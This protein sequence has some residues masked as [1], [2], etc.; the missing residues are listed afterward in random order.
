M[1]IYA[2]IILIALVVNYL[3]DLVSDMLNLQA[4]RQ[5]LPEEFRDVFD[6]SKYQK[7]QEYTRVRTRF[8][9]LTSTVSLLILLAFWF[10]GGFNWVDQFVREFGYGTI[11]TGLLFVG[12]LILAQ[13]I[14]SLPFSIYSTFVIEERFGFNKTRPATFAADRLKGLALTILLGGP[15][16]AGVIGI[17]EYLGAEAWIYAWIVVILFTLIVQFIAPTWIMPLF[18]KFTPLEDGELKQAILRYADKVSFPLK[19]IY[20]I[21]GSRRSSKSNAFFTGFGRNKRIALFDTLIENHTVREL[22]AVLAHEIGHYKKKHIPKNMI[23]SFLH[24]GVMLWLLSLFIRMPGLHEAFFM[25][26]ISVYAGLLFFGL[27]YSPIEMIL[28]VVMQIFSRKHEF[29]ADR[30]A[31]DTTGDP[32][33]M[34]SVLKKLSADN[35]SNL[36]P[37]PFHV[38]LNYSHP[39]V[40]QRIRAIRTGQPG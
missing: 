19:G 14:I 17:F 28:S 23:I 8:G 3:V 10:A 7:A 12:I 34:V 4:L 33:S 32:E 15:L 29:E 37:H 20:K 38:F 35:L 36:T 16:L 30:Y 13:S 2:V 39:P 6:E 27:L 21:D 22:V 40:L 9:L 5:P 18:N 11:V 1:N 31:A 24:T 26:D 25:E